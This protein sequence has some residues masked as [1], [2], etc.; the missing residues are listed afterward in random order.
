[1]HIKLPHL[2]LIEHYQFITFRTQDSV[3][4]YILKISQ[5]TK[6][7]NKQKQYR[8]DQYLDT[9]ENGAYLYGKNIQI[10]KEVILSKEKSN[11]YHVDAF[12]VMPNHVHIL[13]KQ[14]DELANIM[15]YIKAKS[16]IELNRNMNRR[17]KFWLNDYFDKA[18]RDEKHYNLVYEYILNN[19]LKAEL[20]D[21]K[22][23]VYSRF[24]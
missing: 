24:E 21:C 9:S 8:I 2:S 18:V 7:S 22:D 15:K 6:I 10:L 23:R 1:M 3:D 19:P 17:G 13:L 14:K 20:E 11:M 5:D 4:Q 16:A 12:C